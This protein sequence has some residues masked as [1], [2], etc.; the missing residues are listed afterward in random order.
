MRVGQLLA[1][2]SVMFTIALAEK[3]QAQEPTWKPA[4]DQGAPAIRYATKIGDYE[5][6]YV[7]YDGE[8]SLH[9]V[10]PT[11]RGG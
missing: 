3:V 5:I 11:R 1:I 4:L 9:T 8:P 7:T 6:S 2:V 10:R